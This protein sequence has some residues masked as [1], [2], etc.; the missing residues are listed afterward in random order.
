M[1]IIQ[2]LWNPCLTAHI[3]FLTHTFISESLQS[4]NRYLNPTLSEWPS[5]KIGSQA[6]WGS[7][8]KYGTFLWTESA[9]SVH[10]EQEDRACMSLPGISGLSAVSQRLWLSA[11]EVCTGRLSCSPRARCEHCRM[12][13]K[14]LFLWDNSLWKRGWKL[15][16]PGLCQPC[17][18]EMLECFNSRE[19][20]INRN[21]ERISKMCFGRG[22]LSG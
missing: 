11:G 12:L 20:S 18:V 19:M 13:L 21:A 9:S 2:L 8:G 14:A 4:W 3:L 17:E 22:K 16:D 1:G 6:K 7:G 15:R 10:S 5:R